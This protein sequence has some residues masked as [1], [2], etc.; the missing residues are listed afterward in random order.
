MTSTSPTIEQMMAS[1]REAPAQIAALSE[2][3]TAAQLRAAPAEGEWSMVWVLAHLRACADMWGEAMMRIIAEDRPAFQ[4]VNPR[5]W[6]KKT[7]YP[8]LEFAPSFAAFCG[9]RRELL[10]VLEGLPPEG[11]ARTA[12]VRVWGATYER[13][14]LDYAERLARHERSHVRQIARTVEA[15]RAE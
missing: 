10:S 14:A 2:G 13:S 1:L 12:T 7:E 3:L 9:Q 4:A 8:R 15:V 11:W 5:A 6:I